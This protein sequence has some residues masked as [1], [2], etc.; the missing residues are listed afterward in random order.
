KQ[1]S[2]VAASLAGS[3]HS[4]RGEVDL[5]DLVDLITRICR[6]QFA[7]VVGN[8]L[9][10][11]AGGVAF[12]VLWSRRYGA[13]FLTPAQTAHTLHAF[14]PLPSG[15]LIFAAVTGVF[16]WLSS[17]GAGWLENFFV[18]RR[19]GEGIAQ[20]RLGRFIGRARMERLAHRIQHGIAGIGGNVS[21]GFLL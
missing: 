4:A 20:H 16:L 10:G 7:A 8:V 19:I 17:I 11:F 5:S 13:P 21:I 3:L 18:Y 2:M 1:P 14:H 15:T 12:E 6:S 9:V